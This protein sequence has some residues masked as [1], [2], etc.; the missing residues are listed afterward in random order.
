MLSFRG[1]SAD[2]DTLH[3]G[4]VALFVTQG[5]STTSERTELLEFLVGKGLDV[6]RAVMDK[7][8]P[9][10]GAVLAN[11]AGEVKI[12]L[13]TGANPALKDNRFELTPLELALKL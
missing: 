7:L 10:H 4:I 3:Q 2:I 11:S 1:S 12:L 8:L 13:S 5:E 6:N 9:L